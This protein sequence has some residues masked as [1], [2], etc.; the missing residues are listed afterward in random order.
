MS[1]DQNRHLALLTALVDEA[2]DEGA[3]LVTLRAIVEEA[4]STGAARALALCGLQDEAAGNDIRELRNLLEAWRDARRTAWRTL[5]RWIST[6][7]ILALM[8][9][10][11][12]RLKLPFFTQ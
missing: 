5:I 9:G 7:L 3:D 4:S 11:A 10:L 6:A 1:I 2:R 8:A 12:V